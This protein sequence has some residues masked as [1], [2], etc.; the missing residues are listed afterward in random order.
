ME[1]IRH[2]G[3]HTDDLGNDYMVRVYGRE[4][5]DGNWQAWVAFFPL[6]GGRPLATDLETTQSSRSD[7]LYWAMGLETIY[8]AGA[9]TRSHRLRPHDSD[10]FN[11]LAA[12]K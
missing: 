4:D 12:L 8:L 3:S 7:L 11:R 5:E 10:T 6:D 2:L 1:L 9:L